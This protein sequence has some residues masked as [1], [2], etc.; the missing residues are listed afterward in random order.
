[1]RKNKSSRMN[2]QK[3]SYSEILKSHLHSTLALSILFGFLLVLSA[4]IVLFISFGNSFVMQDAVT[5]EMKL[6]ITP[7]GFD[8]ALLFVILFS[9]IIIV[10]YS[11]EKKKNEKKEANKKG[12]V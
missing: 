12:G 8:I 3:S 2:K 9:G 4:S 10:F 7:L 5:E 6:G 11:K 1:M